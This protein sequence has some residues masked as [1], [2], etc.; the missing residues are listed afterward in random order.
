MNQN[1]F[2]RINTY[3]LVS[4]SDF[5]K[6]LYSILFFLSFNSKPYFSYNTKL[7]IFEDILFARVI[8]SKYVMGGTWIRARPPVI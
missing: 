3:S 4:M 2:F 1:P 5:Y 8:L 7:A 6:V